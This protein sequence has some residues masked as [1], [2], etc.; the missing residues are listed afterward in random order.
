M[1][2]ATFIRAGARTP[3]GAPVLPL[4]DAYI[5][6]QYAWQASRGQFMQYNPG[7]TPTSGATGLL[8][9]L[10]LALG[11]LAGIGKDAMLSVVWSFLSGMETGLLVALVI[12]ALWAQ[13]TRR[14]A[15]MAASSALAALTR[16]EAALLPLAIVVAEVAFGRKVVCRPRG[17]GTRFL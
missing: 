12:I 8:Y 2:S 1:V 4:D 7:D 16:P 5:H 9:V 13:V 3:N 15:I 10:L 17:T 14:F 6:L 11:F